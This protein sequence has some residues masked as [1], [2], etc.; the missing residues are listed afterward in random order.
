MN[1]GSSHPAVGVDERL[2]VNPTDACDGAHIVGIVCTQIAEMLRV[3]LRVSFLFLRAFSNAA[4]CLLVRMTPFSGCGVSF[5]ILMVRAN[6]L[7]S[8][9][10]SPSRPVFVNPKGTHCDA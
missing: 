10:I 8:S 7:L 5:Q 4:S 2:P 3:N 6:Q 1:L 9:S